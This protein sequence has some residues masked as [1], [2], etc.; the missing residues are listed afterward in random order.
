MEM[1][2][3]WTRDG[4]GLNFGLH[5]VFIPTNGSILGQ[6]IKLK[7][8]TFKNKILVSNQFQVNQMNVGPLSSFVSINKIAGSGR[9]G[10]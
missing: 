6:R 2:E 5:V 1:P 10:Y 3:V 7:F 8:H 9:V 4:C